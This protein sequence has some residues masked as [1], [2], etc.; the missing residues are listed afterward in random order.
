MLAAAAI[1]LGAATLYPWLA[2][3]SSRDASGGYIETPRSTRAIAPLPP[4]GSFSAVL[5]RPLFSP[6][7]RPAAAENPTGSGLAGRYQL[8]GVV[9]AGGARHALVADGPRRFEIAE[10]AA[11]DGWTVARIEQDR[12]LLSSPT[13]R[14]VL[15]LRRAVAA[16]AVAPAAA[17]PTR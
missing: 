5:D 15:T 6:S 12:V 9:S 1:F 4:F 11:L 8:L 3:M 13:G 10:G 2:P 16:G 17:K 7:R 14:T